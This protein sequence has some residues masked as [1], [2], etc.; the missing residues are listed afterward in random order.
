MNKIYQ[1]IT[2]VERLTRHETLVIPRGSHI[3]SLFFDDDAIR[4]HYI[5][6]KGEFD[7][8]NIS[9]EQLTNGN[10]LVID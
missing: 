10:K 1:D 8:V 3:I 6:P 7:T 4:V 2:I 9:Y 5:N